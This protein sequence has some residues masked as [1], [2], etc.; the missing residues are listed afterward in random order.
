MV[1]GNR[2][3]RIEGRARKTPVPVFPLDSAL[4]NSPSPDEVGPSWSDVEDDQSL[5][6][7]E[8][9]IDMGAVARCEGNSQHMDLERLYSVIVHDRS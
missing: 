3:V 1:D 9:K 4:T 5:A 2:S 6:A 7:A 8:M